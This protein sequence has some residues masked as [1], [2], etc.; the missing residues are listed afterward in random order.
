MEER[1]DVSALFSL[2]LQWV[3]LLRRFAFRVGLRR[4]ARARVPVVSIGNI[5]FGGTGKTPMVIALAKALSARGVKVCI[6][7]RGYRRKKS[8]PTERVDP[9][10]EAARFGDEPL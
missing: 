4:Q 10:G 6:L 9:N 1:G 5:S 2:I 8:Q 3:S 7:S